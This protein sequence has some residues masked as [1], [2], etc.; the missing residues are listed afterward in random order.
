MRT[1][2]VM[3]ILAAQ[4]GPGNVCELRDVSR[5]AVLRGG[6]VIDAAE[7][8]TLRHAPGH[9]IRIDSGTWAAGTLAPPRAPT[10][11]TTAAT[12]GGSLHTAAAARLL[13]VDVKTLPSERQSLGLGSNRDDDDA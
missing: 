4:S 5:Q 2:T 3:A 10:P 11:R 1:P 13:K 7:I 12:V 6:D 8:P 9:R